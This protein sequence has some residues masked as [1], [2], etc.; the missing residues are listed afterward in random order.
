MPYKSSEAFLAPRLSHMS[1]IL[2]RNLRFTK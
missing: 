2:S 1:H